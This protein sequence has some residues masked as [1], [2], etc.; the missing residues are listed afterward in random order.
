[1]RSS[2]DLDIRHFKVFSSDYSKWTG[3]TSDEDW[4][5]GDWRASD[6]DWMNGDWRASE[7]WIGWLLEGQV[8]TGLDGDGMVTK[9]GDLMKDG[10]LLNEGIW[11]RMD[12]Y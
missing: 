12:I 6:E 11:W 8:R 7:D 4:M 1:M 10:Y 3:K 9:W 2:I 5:N